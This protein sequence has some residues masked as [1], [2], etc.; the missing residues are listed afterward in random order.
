MKWV[1]FISEQHALFRVAMWLSGEE[2]AWHWNIVAVLLLFTFFHLLFVIPQ[3]SALIRKM[4]FE[5]EQRDCP[6]F[7]SLVP[8][9]HTLDCLNAFH[10][11]ASG[12]FVP[13]SPS[14]PEPASL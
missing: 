4:L 2:L 10:S 3:L 5:G 12:G 8:N 9:N 6:A 11:V 1:L 13:L 7:V 14:G